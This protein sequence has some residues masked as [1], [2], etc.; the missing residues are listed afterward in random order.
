[1]NLPP[2]SGINLHAFRWDHA[3]AFARWLLKDDY[4]GDVTAYLIEGERFEVGDGL[5]PRVDAAVGQLVDTLLADL[6]PN[7][8]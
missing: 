1:E 5:S 7:P 3:I 2:P 6:A 4:P 8:A